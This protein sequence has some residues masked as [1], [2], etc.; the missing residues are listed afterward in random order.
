MGRPRHGLR[1]WAVAAG[2]MLLAGAVA[3]IAWPRLWPGEVSRQGVVF[4]GDS[5]TSGDGVPPEATFA[6]RIGVALGVRVWNAGVSGDTT[7]GALR[8][9]GTDVLAHR[10]R[11]VVVELGV[12][13]E[14]DH[15]RPVSETVATL[16]QIVR[17]LRKRGIAVVLVYTPF[18]DFD[19]DVYRQGLRDIARRQRARLVESFYDGIVPKLTVDGLHPSIEGHAVLARR[20]EPV[21]RELLGG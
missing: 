4:L 15:R 5:I 20:L 3:A 17:R 16:E 2:L 13:D 14:V 6:H 9:L 10:P 1:G 11:V 8:R 21:V 12:N 7:S 19:R 18:G